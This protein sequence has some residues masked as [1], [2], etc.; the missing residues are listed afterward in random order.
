MR[1][2]SVEDRRPN[3]EPNRLSITSVR[4]LTS[5]GRSPFL[6]NHGPAKATPTA[7][8]KLP[9]KRKDSLDIRRLVLQISQPR[10]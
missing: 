3:D 4:L 6:R 9:S 8:S 2:L 10:Y 5:M 7:A 1:M